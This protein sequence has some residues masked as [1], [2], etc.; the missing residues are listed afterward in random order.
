MFMLVGGWLL[1]KFYGQNLS[2]ST[3]AKNT[4]RVSNLLHI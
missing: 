3:C 4:R 1:A 2:I